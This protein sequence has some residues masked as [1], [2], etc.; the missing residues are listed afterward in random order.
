MTAMAATSG[1]FDASSSMIHSGARSIIS[2][3]SPGESATDESGAPMWA[4]LACWASTSI[5]AVLFFLQPIL[6]HALAPGRED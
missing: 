5:G 3:V 2:L 1:A 6:A 4:W